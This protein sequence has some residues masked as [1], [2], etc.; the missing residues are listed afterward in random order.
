MQGGIQYKNT[1]NTFQCEVYEVFML[2]NPAGL[3]V[4]I[5]GKICYL[6]HMLRD[7]S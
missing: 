6:F 5:L 4:N 7:L 1:E 3:V 2:F